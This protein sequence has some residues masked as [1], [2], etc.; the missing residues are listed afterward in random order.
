MTVL[1]SASALHKSY[2]LPRRSLFS[3][4]A[5]RRAVGGVD[6]ELAE[7]RHLGIVGESGSGKSTLTRLLL[8]LERPDAGE[9]RF[10]DVRVTPGRQEWFRREVQVVLQDPRASLDPRMTVRQIVAEPLECLRVAGDVRARVAEVLTAVGLGP[11]IMGRYPHEFSGGQR[12]R[13]A[14]ARALAPGPKVL[15]GDEPLSAL[16]V[17]VRSS[18]LALLRTLADE[19][20]LTLVLVSHD[21]GV[22]QQLCADV[23][24]MKDGVV[25][26]RGPTS[27]VLSAPQHPYTQALLA[28]VPQLPSEVL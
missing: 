16:D 24:V 18:V 27:Q 13:I 10:R 12:Q 8:G 19:F 6:L 3:S 21:I 11:E 2:R 4:A 22:V 26:E 23:L 1:L 25:V 9:V 14:I 17:V 15:I 7:G 20:G 5:R 28:A